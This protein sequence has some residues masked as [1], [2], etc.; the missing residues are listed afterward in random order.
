MADFFELEQKLEESQN[1]EQELEKIKLGDVEY[2]QEELQQLVALGKLGKEAEEKFNTKLDK[3]WPEFS[4]S[5]NELKTAREELQ[6]LKQQAQQVAQTKATDPN[7]T[8]E[9]RS[10]AREQ[11]KALGIVTQDQLD[12]YFENHFQQKYSTTREAERLIEETSKYASDINGSDGRPA[13]KQQE[14]LEYMRDN[15]IK[16]PMIAYKLKYEGELDTWKEQQIGQSKKAAFTTQ[17]NSSFIKE[18]KEIRP[19]KGNLE[20]LIAESLGQE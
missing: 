3:V 19:N 4:R 5:Q 9:E 13:F 16:S 11:A 8:E 17:T 14:I 10:T 2:G 12:E 20:S 15:G 7:L 1:N 6:T 18:P